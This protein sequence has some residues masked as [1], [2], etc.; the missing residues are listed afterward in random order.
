MG[1]I[2]SNGQAACEIGHI[3]HSTIHDNT[4]DQCNLEKKF[5]FQGGA[6]S[7]VARPYTRQPLID[8]PIISTGYNYGLVTLRHLTRSGE[9]QLILSVIK[10]V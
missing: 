6:Q 10:T 7:L 8:V 9:L 4:I 3:A 2:I 5:R 1:C